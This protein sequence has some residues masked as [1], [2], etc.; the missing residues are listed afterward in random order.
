MFSQ[1]IS[2]SLRSDPRVSGGTKATFHVEQS[3]RNQPA[4]LCGWLSFI[5]LSVAYT[6]MEMTVPELPVW[7]GMAAL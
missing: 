1:L 4:P 3:K 7:T 5:L 2:Q 6:E